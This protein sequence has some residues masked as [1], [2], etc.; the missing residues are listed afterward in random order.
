[1]TRNIY[2]FRQRVRWAVYV[3]LVF[4]AWLAYGA[5]THGLGVGTWNW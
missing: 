2:K 4:V 5:V 3:V 1:M